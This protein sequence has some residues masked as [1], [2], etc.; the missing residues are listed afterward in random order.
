M[1]SPDQIFQEFL[2]AFLVREG[3]LFQYLRWSQP[4]SEHKFC[5][6]NPYR[7]GEAFH[8]TVTWADT[9]KPT[10]YWFQ[11]SEKF[12]KEW[13]KYLEKHEQEIS[14]AIARSTV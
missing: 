10:D 8:F 5:T 6:S 3:I 1:K 4:L 9:D 7:E 14:E 13:F 2:Y 12:D 11:L